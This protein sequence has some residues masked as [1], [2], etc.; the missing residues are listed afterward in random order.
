MAWV[1]EIRCRLALPME[2][3]WDLV[4]SPVTLTWISAPLLTFRPLEP[5]RFPERWSAGRHRVSMAFLGVLP[6]GRQWIDISFPEPGPD[7]THGTRIV[8]D[9]GTGQLVKRWDHW[10][11]MAPTDDGATD[12]RDRVAIEAGLL[13]PFIWLFAQGFYRWRQRRWRRIAQGDGPAA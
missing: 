6:L 10:I 1:V 5:P 3:A 11:I 13:T 8:R 12:Y 9:N 2:R 7:H 4:R